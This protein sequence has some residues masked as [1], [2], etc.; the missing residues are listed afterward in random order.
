MVRKQNP[1]QEVRRFMRQKDLGVVQCGR[2]QR[3]F[4][5]SL[6]FMWCGWLKSQGVYK[7][8]RNKNTLRKRLGGK[9]ILSHCY[10]C[11]IYRQLCVIAHKNYLKERNKLTLTNCRK[12]VRY[13]SCNCYLFLF[14]FLSNAINNL[15]NYTLPLLKHPIKYNT[16]SRNLVL[17]LVFCFFWVWF[18]VTR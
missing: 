1:L 6:D 14:F 12:L 2:R 11:C 8:E 4:N 13:G 3:R 18:W 17:H 10:F 5:L 15:I 9:C 16:L 7:C